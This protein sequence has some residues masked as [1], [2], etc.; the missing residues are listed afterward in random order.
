MFAANY[1]RLVDKRKLPLLLP[2]AIPSDKSN[3]LKVLFAGLFV[4]RL[5][6]D[7]TRPIDRFEFA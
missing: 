1:V 5:Y 4:Y 7:L 3:P 2:K 6:P